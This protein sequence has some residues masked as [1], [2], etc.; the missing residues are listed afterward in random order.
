MDDAGKFSMAFLRC[1][2]YKRGNIRVTWLEMSKIQLE[3]GVSRKFR[4]AIR[5]FACNNGWRGQFEVEGH[6][7]F[8]MCT[9]ETNEPVKFHATE[10]LNGGSWY[11]HSMIQYVAHD[12][13]KADT[14]CPA[15]LC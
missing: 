1:D 11:D 5:K 13:D 9:P 3:I 10:Y 12:K 2:Y 14:V 6:T 7:R 4:Y 15:K 8:S